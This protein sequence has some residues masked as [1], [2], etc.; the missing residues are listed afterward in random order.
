MTQ[1]S[2]NQIA[3]GDG[4]QATSLDDLFGGRA[5][6]WG[7]FKGDGTAAMRDSFGVSS[8]TD[9][10]TGDYTWTAAT[11]FGSANHAPALNCDRVINTTQ[12][13]EGVQYGAMS[14]SALR[15]VC[16]NTTPSA[17]DQELVSGTVHGDF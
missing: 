13:T 2:S 1:I 17:V 8:T 12:S 14:A 16:A 3:K 10:G 4:S 5:K 6:M 7:N 15:F 9:H 11:A